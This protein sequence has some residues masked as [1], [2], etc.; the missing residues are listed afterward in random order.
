MNVVHE[1]PK[2]AED[3][4]RAG[5][6][7]VVAQLQAAGEA[8]V[9]DEYKIPVKLHAELQIAWDYYPQIP[10]FMEVRFCNRNAVFSDFWLSN[11]HN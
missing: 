4:V 5:A 8:N 9:G 7:I 10:H 11:L 3:I 1:Q 2:D 6:G